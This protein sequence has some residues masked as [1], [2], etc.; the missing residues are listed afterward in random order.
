MK[1][2]KSYVMVYTILMIMTLIQY[3]CLQNYYHHLNN[4]SLNTP[5]VENYQVCYQAFILYYPLTQFIF[6]GLN[7]VLYYHLM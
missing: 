6:V 3:L 5:I 1:N 2:P 7:H 4:I